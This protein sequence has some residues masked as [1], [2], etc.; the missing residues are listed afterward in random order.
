MKS[1]FDECPYPGDLFTPLT[2][3]ERE[4]IL[5]AVRATG[6]KAATDRLFSEWGRSV[7]S[8][9]TTSA[10]GEMQALKD[11]NAK[12]KAELQELRDRANA[13]TEGAQDGGV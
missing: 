7:W 1:A 4:R 3:D 6:I 2:T 5:T 9:C 12:L 8:A 10:G 11:Q 13:N